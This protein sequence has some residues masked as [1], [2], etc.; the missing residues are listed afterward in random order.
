[1]NQYHTKKVIQRYPSGGIRKVHNS[2]KA[3]ATDNDDKFTAK[4][5]YYHLRKQGYTLWRGYYWEW[6]NGKGRNIRCIG[7]DCNKMFTSVGNHNRLCPSCQN[8]DKGRTVYRTPHF[9]NAKKSDS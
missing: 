9:G 4:Q 2:A 7:L 6:D 8:I 3:A 5:L 1:M